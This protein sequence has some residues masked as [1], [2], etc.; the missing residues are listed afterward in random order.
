MHMT[1]VSR[2]HRQAA[3]DILTRSVPTQQGL[4]SE[5]MPKVVQA[6]SVAVIHPAQSDLA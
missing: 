3:L 2:Q 1:K 6:R 4:D 5:S